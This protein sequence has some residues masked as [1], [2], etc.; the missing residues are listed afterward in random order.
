MG[1]V[2]GLGHRYFLPNILMSPFIMLCS[3]YA[4]SVVKIVNKK[5][6]AHEGAVMMQSNILGQNTKSVLL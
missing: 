4:D 3:P 5:Q 6:I 1:I 2:L